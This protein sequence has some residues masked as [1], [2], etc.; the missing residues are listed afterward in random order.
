[1]AWV[2]CMCADDGA[3]KPLFKAH[4]QKRAV[5]LLDRFCRTL[6]R[7]TLYPEDLLAIRQA[8]M[9]ELLTD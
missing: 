4:S 1:M 9:D 2:V 3:L 5:E 7:V 6:P 8:P